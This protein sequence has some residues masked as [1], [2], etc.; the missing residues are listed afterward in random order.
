MDNKIPDKV[1]EYWFYGSPFGGEN[2]RY[3]VIIVQGANSLIYIANGHFMQNLNGLWEE[4][5][6]IPNYPHQFQG[7]YHVN[8][9]KNIPIESI[10]S[11]L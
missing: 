2:K 7:I 6:N 3:Y 11:I 9:K 8:E 10:Q 4:I 5:S 1:G